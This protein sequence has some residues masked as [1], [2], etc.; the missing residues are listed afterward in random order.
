MT[1]RVSFLRRLSVGVVDQLLSSGS[2]FVTLLLGARYLGVKGFGTFSLAMLSFTLTLGITRAL[3]GE[4]MLVRPGTSIDE[5]RQR[6]RSAAGSVVWVGLVVGAG[7]A[8]AALSSSGTFARCFAVMAVAIT[9]LLVQD[10]LRY[11]AFSRAE[12]RAALTSDLMWFS[13][14]AVLMVVLIHRG[15]P[16][17]AEMLL[18]FVVPGVIAGAVQAL[19]ERVAPQVRGGAGWI[20]ANRDLSVRYALDF[21]SGTGAAQ[22]S[23]YV[24]A[25]VGG[26]AAVGSL[27][28]GQTLFGPVNI[29]L[30]GAYIVLV[31]EGRHAARRS[32]RSLTTVCVLASGSFALFA[33]TMLGL[34]LVLSPAQG[35]MILGSTWRGAHDIIV[36]VGI[37]AIA[38]GVLAGASAGLRSLA[39]AREILRIR[40][41]TIPTTLALPV[42]GALLADAKGLAWGIAIS[43][44]WNVGWYWATYFRALRNFDPSVVEE[45]VADADQAQVSLRSGG[46]SS[47]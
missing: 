19:R 26:V 44:W 29:F 5:H 4:A 8:V 17:A 28:G 40:L 14:T 27:R 10:V 9:G 42:T 43:V 15:S 12:P 22:L 35:E 6:V 47:R 37:A 2:N 3:C 25:I 13:G 32:K 7:M 38:G 31:P 36:P 33:G 45:L 21:L 24:L 1:S 18:A 30:T 39:A 23:A 20:L 11:A 41:F 34:Y 16:T 46:R